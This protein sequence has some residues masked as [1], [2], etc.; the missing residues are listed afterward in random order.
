MIKF[1]DTHA[2]INYEEYDSKERESL[3]KEIQDTEKMAFV[4]DVGFDLPSSQQAIEDAE[5]YDWIYA[6]VGI[7]PHDTDD[8]NQEILDKLRSLA[9]GSDR[10]VAI[11]EIGLD[12]H[13]DNSHRDNQ[14]K[15]FR[16]Q[17]QLAN[18]L[19]LPIVI[20]SRDA[21]QETMDIL[22]EE[23][24]FSDER[25]SFFPKRRAPEGTLVDDARVLIHCFSG[26][27]QL[28]E[29][30]VKLGATISIGGPVTFKNNKRTRKV[31]ERIPIEYILIETDTPY[32]TPEPYRGRPNK[33]YLVEHTALKIAELKGMELSQVAE[34]TLKNGKVFYGISDGQ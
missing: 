3:V 14:R 16:K 5:T 12:Y 15:W 31:A 26:S 22:V 11:G 19:K 13:Y 29:Q 18:E 8:M 27:A 7:H 21:H 9:E 17:I 4:A 32:L 30:Y 28:A 2:H 20:H 1:F 10:V 33:P 25:K 34:E 24:A 23:G 6:V